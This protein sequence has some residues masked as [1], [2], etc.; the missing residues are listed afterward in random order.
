MNSPLIRKKHCKEIIF[1]QF[2]MQKAVASY[3]EFGRVSF[4]HIGIEAQLFLKQKGPGV[5]ASVIED[6]LWFDL[7]AP[8]GVFIGRSP[9]TGFVVQAFESERGSDSESSR[10]LTYSHQER[11]MLRRRKHTSKPLLPE[12]LR[13]L[14]L[15]ADG[16]AQCFRKLIGHTRPAPT[17]SPPFIL[18]PKAHNTRGTQD[19]SRDLVLLQ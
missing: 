6:D 5:I 1:G 18:L 10:Y 3:D 12:N 7:S 8:D 4:F 2:G 14:S 15:L 13:D 16:F 11:L 17:G 19:F 9:Q